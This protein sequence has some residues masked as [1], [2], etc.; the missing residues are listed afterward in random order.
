MARIIVSLLSEH[1]IPN[2]L[3]IKEMG[4]DKLLFLTTKEMKLKNV[5]E[6]TLSA[7]GINEAKNIIQLLVP[8]DDF[9]EIYLKLG[10]LLNSERNFIF[11]NDE[12]FVN[13]TG[14]TKIMSLAVY[15][16]FRDYRKV[17]IVY[18]PIGKNLYK[19]IIPLESRDYPLKSRLGLKEYLTAYGYEI[20]EA[21]APEGDENFISKRK[22]M[23]YEFAKLYKDEEKIGRAHV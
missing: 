13:L 4:F 14:G 18:L 9:Q 3:F 20:I 7:L 15:G 5:F 11:P 6:N 8:N 12:I 23:V 19:Q 10:S 22:Q 17:K 1:P 21:N 2:I 16:F